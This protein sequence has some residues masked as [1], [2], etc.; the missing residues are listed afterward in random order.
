[1]HMGICI[2]DIFINDNITSAMESLLRKH[3]GCGSDGVMLSEV[4]DYWAING[5]AIKKSIA[6]RVYTL[7]LVNQEEIVNRKGKR[8]TISVMNTVDRLIYRALYQKMYELWSPEFSE[9]SYAYQEQKG[10][11]IAVE[12][13]AFYIQQGSQW[14]AE[15]DIYHFFDY[16]DHQIL[17]SIL[18]EKIQDEAVLHMILAYLKCT[19]LNDHI[20]SQ[21]NVGLLQGGALSPL[22]SN[23]YLND[24]DHYM[25]KQGYQFCRFGDDINIYS[26]SYETSAEQLQ[27]VCSYLMEKKKLILNEEKTG[28]FKGLNRKYLGYRFEMKQGSVLIKKEN[29]AYRTVYRDWYTTGIQRVDQ[30]YHLLNEGILTKHDYTILFEGNDGKKYIP[31]ETTDSLYIYSNVIFS[32]HFFD[33]MNATGLNVCMINK[34][35]EKIGGFVPQNN[36]RN[37]KMEL[38]QLHVYDD[39]QER[40]KIARKL[41]IASISNIRAN[42]RYYGRRKASEEL[43]EVVTQ[44]STM[45]KE[46]NEARDI[47]QLM[48]IEAR[49]R[50]KYYSCFNYILENKKFRFE[51]RTRRPP[52]DPLNA[53]ISFGNTLLYQKIANEI[54]RTSLDIRIGI[55]HA[56]GSRQESL[57]LDLADLFKSIIVDRTIFTLVNRK[58]IDT[59]D[60][61]EVENDGVFISN[62]GKKL[63]IQEF[64][65]KLYQ[66]IEIDNQ[67]RSYEYVIRREIQK[68][69]NFMETGEEYKPYKYV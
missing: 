6:D 55:V 31:V 4:E 19:I 2:E 32:Q 56:A 12:Q 64:E 63:F 25:E 1:M 22:L 9:Y 8:R 53:M 45:I 48:M 13:A 16:I 66:K 21:K 38:K 35:G 18:R 33:F 23:I 27:D 26:Q 20:I 67:K 42:L 52:R 14:C 62:R 17:L 3:D 40:L 65:R 59:T 36:R 54:N 60:F 30:T 68:L 61:V 47:T 69:K 57:N 28:I 44:I 10:I 7:G 51:K 49:A 50:Q 58:M 29:R 11:V 24:L 5:D 39:E 41:E 43:R 37:I 15:L 34:Y 46:L